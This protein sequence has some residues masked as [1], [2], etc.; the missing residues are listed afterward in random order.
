MTEG[1]VALVTG[2]S[3]GIGAAIAAALAEAGFRVA[4]TATSEAGAASIGEALGAEHLGL[5]MN[6]ESDD[7]VAEALKAV[8]A[9]LGAP[10]VLVNNAGITQDNLMLRMSL[11]QW[12]KVMD[13]NANGLFRVTKP[14]LRGMMKARFGRIINLSS[15]IARRGN[16]GQ[17][18]YAAS[19]G[20]VEGFTRALAQ[21]VGSRGITVNAV[22]PGFI[23]TEMTA[24]LGEEVT[25][26]LRSAIALGR[27]GAASE[28]AALVA[29]LASDGAGY[30]TGETIAINGGLYMN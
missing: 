1:K 23:E 3:R 26:N 28:V 10:L 12:V 29:F 25:E 7:S 24:G 18:N 14:L 15:V 9:T 22:A 21:E 5:E 30:I 8:E 11:E 19:K 2:A 6:L 27:F 16:A 20:A 13:T 17:A 4:G